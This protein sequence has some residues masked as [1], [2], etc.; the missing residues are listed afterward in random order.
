MKKK[1]DTSSISIQYLPETW[2]IVVQEYAIFF[3]AHRATYTYGNHPTHY[4][5]HDNKIA[6]LYRVYAICYSNVV[7]YY[8]TVRGIRYYIQEWRLA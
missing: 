7:S 4:T 5:V 1:N 3:Q 2:R 8:V 6:R